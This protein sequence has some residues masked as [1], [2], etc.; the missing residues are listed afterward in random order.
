MILTNLLQ[1]NDF[2]NHKGGLGGGNGVCDSLEKASVSSFNINQVKRIKQFAVQD[3]GS[4]AG[5]GTPAKN[6]RATV[7]HPRG[8]VRGVE[9]GS[10]KVATNFF[11]RLRKEGVDMDP[12]S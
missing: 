7:N 4:G 5:I 6:R 8:G 10:F 9:Y 2:L 11:L 12:P 1:V 3:N